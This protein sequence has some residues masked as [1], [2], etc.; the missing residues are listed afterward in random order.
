MRN[1]KTPGLFKRDGSIWHYDILIDGQRFRGST[2]TADLKTAS[3]FLSQLRLDIARGSLSLKD[4][5]KVV[6]LDHVFQEFIAAKSAS[7]SPIYMTSVRAHWRLWLQA[8]FIGTPV[9]KV[10]AT[11]VD[12]L[13]NA[14]LTSGHSQVY[15]NNVLV[16]LRTLLNFAVKRGRCKKALRVELLRI[17][18]IPRTT[19]PAD[20]VK[21]FLKALDSFARNPHARLMVRV[22]LALG[23]RSSEVAG[24]RWEWLNLSQRTYTVGRAKGKE[25]R[26]LPC[27]D[28]LLDLLTAM[29]KNTLSGLI[30]PTEEGKAHSPGFLRKPLLAAAKSLN[31]GRLTPH[32]LRATF[33]SLHAEAGT[34][35]SELQTLMG[36]KDYKTLWGYIEQSLDARR[37]A[38]D[39]LSQKLGLA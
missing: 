20:K 25:A 9:D 26:V 31:L 3:L 29:P 27:P 24:M 16:S 28:W 36:H 8:H 13:R 23:L 4:S 21:D 35:L 22:M 2:K 38:Q 5:R 15:T 33:A 12:H 7:T 30:F 19:V 6:L 1:G 34:P 17:Q 18:R 32:R 11:Q 39:T 14:L 37:K 10:D